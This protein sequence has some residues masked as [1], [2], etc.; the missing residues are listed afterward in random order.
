MKS[1][2]PV[3]LAI[4]TAVQAVALPDTNAV[5]GNLL[6]KRDCP[7]VAEQL[8]TDGCSPSNAECEF[9]CPSDYVPPSGYH[10]H[11]G[12]GSDTCSDTESEWHCEDH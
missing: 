11:G 3:I 9:C 1:F 5:R 6:V 4:A 8:V 12:H 10:C 2:A 7:G